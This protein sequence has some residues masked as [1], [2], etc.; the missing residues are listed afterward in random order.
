[1]PLINDGALLDAFS[2]VSNKL[3]GFGSNRDPLNSNTFS[4]GLR[5]N[6]E[7]LTAIYRSSKLIQ[8]IIDR[9]PKD[10]TCHE[11]IIKQGDNGTVDTDAIL[12]KWRNLEV[13]AIGDTYRGVN[14]AFE[15]AGILARLYGNAYIIIGIDDGQDFDQPVDEANIQSIRWLAVRDRTFIKPIPSDRSLYQLQISIENELPDGESGLKIHRSRLL[16]FHGNRLRGYALKQSGR[17]YEDDPIIEALFEQFCSFLT[18][19]RSGASM[20]A[21]HSVFKYK[22]N[23]LARLTNQENT[24]LLQARFMGIIKG[25]SSMKGLFFDAQQEDADFIN[26]TYGGVDGL[27]NVLRDLFVSVSEMPHSMLFGTPTGGAFSESGA[28]DRYEWASNVASYQR[29]E[30]LPNHVEL[31]RLSCLAKDSPTRGIYPEDLSI[32]YPSILQLTAK[33]KAEIRK[34]HA[35]TDSIYID[36]F[37]LS[38][39]EARERFAGSQ[40]SDEIDLIEGIKIEQPEQATVTDAVEIINNKVRINGQLLPLSEYGEPDEEEPDEEN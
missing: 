24:E 13:N 36:K 11:P 27:V 4:G 28:S 30:F 19:S 14:S 15:E 32:E 1:M 8:K 16:K 18:A 34:I 20:L 17:V 39:L 6:E 25:L 33:E 38:P 22:L 40:Y 7:S 23:G 9:C 2:A 21:S 26:R 12:S 29:S 37:V 35:E 31:L 10:A 5:L 3:L